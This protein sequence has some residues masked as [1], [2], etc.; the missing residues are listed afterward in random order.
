MVGQRRRSPRRK[1]LAGNHQRSWLWGRNAVIETLRAGR[2][3]P[4]ELVLADSADATLAAQVRDFAEAG[5]VPLKVETTDRLTDLVHARDHQGLLARMPEFP[6]SSV[7]DILEQAA[8]HARHVSRGPELEFNV[9]NQTG[10]DKTNQPLAAPELC[11]ILDAIQDPFNFGAICRVACIYGVDGVITGSHSQAE[12]TPHVVRSSA[13]AVSRLDIARV[14]ELAD[15]VTEFK[16]AGFKVVGTSP[17]AELTIDQSDLTGPLAFIIGSEG[18]GLGETLEAECDELVRIP[19]AVS[20]DSLN[21]AV[22]AGI[23]CY[24]IHR[25]RSR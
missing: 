17:R 23:L 9:E 3:M 18:P 24:E 2:W 15:S 11:L 6:Y 16:T 19:Q 21:A 5:D 13:G 12:V 22:S 20:F 8:E 1:R 10:A 25:Q 4:L 14:E 7:R